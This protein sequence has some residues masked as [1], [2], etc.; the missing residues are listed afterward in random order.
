MAIPL[1][2]SEVAGLLVNGQT[3]NS[4]KIFVGGQRDTNWVIGQDTVVTPFTQV[5]WEHQFSTDR[6]LTASYQSLPGS[7]FVV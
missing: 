2:G 4:D 1:A 3:V 6:K 5:G 7:G